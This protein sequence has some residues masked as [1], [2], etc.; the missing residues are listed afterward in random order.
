MKKYIILLVA[1]IIGVFATAQTV[2]LPA[3]D[4]ETTY[5]Y[6][7]TDY[8]FTNNVARVFVFPVK[9][10]YK[11]A[12]DYVIKLDSVSGNHTSVTVVLAGSKSA[13]KNDWTTIGTV[14]WTTVPKPSADTTIIISNA[15]ANRYR[16]FR[17]TVTGAGTGVSK[18]SDQE[19]K[20]WRE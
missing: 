18:V 12:Q 2:T 10:H 5:S 8:T 14:I 1:M 15:T 13:L 16:Y 11:T 19:L 17:A 6:V 7:S 4:T 3:L 20:L 9:Q